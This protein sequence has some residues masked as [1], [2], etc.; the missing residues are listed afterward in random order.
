MKYVTLIF[1]MVVL[2]EVLGYIA[3]SLETVPFQPGPVAIWTTIVGTL[4]TVIF[5]K[6]SASASDS[7][8]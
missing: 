3:S 7:K 6:I 2:G 1:W 5:A 8:K 4:G